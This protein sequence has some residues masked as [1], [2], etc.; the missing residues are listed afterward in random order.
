LT[1]NVDEA[2][3]I[4]EVPFDDVDLTPQPSQPEE[5]ARLQDD[6]TYA[7]VMHGGARTFVFVRE[8]AA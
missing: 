3:L 1:V 8:H 6:D 4:R 7:T 2:K 5:I